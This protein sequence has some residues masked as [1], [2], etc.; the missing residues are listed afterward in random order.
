MRA[1]SRGLSKQK[2]QRN[3]WPR[4]EKAGGFMPNNFC[5]PKAPG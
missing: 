1:A 4:R 5:A 2:V 3:K